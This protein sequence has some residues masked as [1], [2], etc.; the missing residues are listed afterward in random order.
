MLYVV[1]RRLAARHALDLPTCWCCLDEARDAALVI[2]P[3]CCCTAV[4][5]SGELRC[6]K[7]S[8]ELVLCEPVIAVAVAA[9]AAVEDG[10]AVGILMALP[11]PPP[12][13]FGYFCVDRLM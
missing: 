5:F 11:P 10:A 6:S 1:C 4:R 7:F 13:M 9:A 2:V 12:L 3:C 8:G